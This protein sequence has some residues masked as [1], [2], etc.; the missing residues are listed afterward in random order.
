MKLEEQDVAAAEGNQELVG[1]ED[2]GKAPE[3]AEEK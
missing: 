1:E 3:S 2:S